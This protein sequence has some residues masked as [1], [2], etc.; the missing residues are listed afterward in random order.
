MSRTAVLRRVREIAP[1]QLIFFKNER[2]PCDPI[3]SWAIPPLS[4]NANLKDCKA[5]K[6]LFSVHREVT[7]RHSCL[8]HDVERN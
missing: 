1:H 8:H 7:I 5:S 2:S 4:I 6:T 3:H